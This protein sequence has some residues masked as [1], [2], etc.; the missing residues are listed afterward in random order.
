MPPR[1]VRS[2]ARRRLSSVTFVVISLLLN[3]RFAQLAHAQVLPQQQAQPQTQPQ[4]Q[5]QP[6]PQPQPQTQPQAQPVHPQPAPAAPRVVETPAYKALINDAIKEYEARHFEEARSLFVK[7]IA[8]VPS[9]RAL[10]GLGMSEFELRDYADSANSLQQALASNVRP[11]EGALR[12][13]TERLL[14]RARGFVARLS[15]AVEPGVA[16]VVVDGVP[17]QLGAQGNLVLEVGDHTLEF[18]AEGYRPESRRLKVKGG[19]EE[20]MRI[21]LPASEE[22]VNLRVPNPSPQPQPWQ[23]AP[24]QH[25][26]THKPL[27]KNPWLWTAVGVVVAGVATGLAIGLSRDPGTAHAIASSGSASLRAP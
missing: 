23:P 25:D 15:V 4:T 22:Q 8:I 14:E 7:A 16:T 11:L 3:P 17:V 1:A 5:P 24:A 19:E 27:Y 2:V 13:E 6:Q 26:D 20:Q 10:R 12:A 21:V 18:R 9:A